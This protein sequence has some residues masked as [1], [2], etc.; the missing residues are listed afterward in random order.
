VAFF[1]V[2]RRSGFPLMTTTVFVLM[3][4]IIMHVF[5]RMSHRRMGVLMALMGVGNVLMGVLM[6]VFVFV[7]ATHGYLSPFK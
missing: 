1:G 2:T 5:M 3:M 6:L 4:S 7:V